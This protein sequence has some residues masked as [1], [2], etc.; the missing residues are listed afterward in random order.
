MIVP[1]PDPG[2]DALA[3]KLTVASGAATVVDGVKAAVGGSSTVTVWVV[4]LVC[5][6]LFVTVSVAVYVPRVA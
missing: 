6:K 1:P 2:A 4:V 3:L 5:P